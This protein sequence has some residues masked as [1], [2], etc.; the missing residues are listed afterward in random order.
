ML[1]FTEYCLINEQTDVSITNGD[2]NKILRKTV[3]M[4]KKLRKS[5]LK[6]DQ[7]DADYLEYSFKPAL[8]A[9]KLKDIASAMSGGETETRDEMFKIVSSVVGKD[10][11]QALANMR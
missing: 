8:N 10:Q 5:S 4:I 9:R 1:K 3:Q 2:V 11:A 6:A 7:Q